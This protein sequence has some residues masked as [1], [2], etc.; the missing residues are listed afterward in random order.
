M[1]RRSISD[2]IRMIPF[3]TGFVICLAFLAS[4]AA[5]GG[6]PF[7]TDDPEP[8]ELHHGEFYIASEYAENRDGKGGTLPHFE[9]NYGPIPD[10]QL[11]LI[12]PLAYAHPN[13][14][15]TMYGLGDMEV[16]V[17]YRFIHESD[18]IPQV[19]AFPLVH[20]PTGNTDRGLGSGH[21]PVFLPV[22]M[23]KS[24]GPWTSYGG[25][26]YWINPGGGN[27][28]F[29]QLGWLG[30]RDINRFLTIGAEIFY[31][32]MDTVGGRDQ[33]GYNIGGIFNLSGEHHILFSAGSD[34]AG[35]N[36]FS[37]YLAYQ[38]TFGHHEGGK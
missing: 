25:G 34:I 31:F 38:L 2:F 35:N 14:G 10:L 15:P 26:G 17:K 16:G 37:A 20:I 24:W 12:V 32:G 27:R 11:H 19:G 21:L 4:S 1:Q 33:T 6:P 9:F 5:W 3:C 18:M 36:R 13:A 28:N 8:V 29:W 22:W 30:Q 23:Q 7:V